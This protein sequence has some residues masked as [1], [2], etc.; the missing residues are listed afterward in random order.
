MTVC[1]E[2]VK[3]YPNNFQTTRGDYISW[4]VMGQYP[5]GGG[6]QGQGYLGPAT[7]AAAPG[8]EPT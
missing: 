5:P 3:R 2:F 6:G 4:L 8:P 7:Q 1:W